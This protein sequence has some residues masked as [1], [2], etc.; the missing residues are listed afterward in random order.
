MIAEVN[1]EL[2]YIIGANAPVERREMQA[3]S[4]GTIKQTT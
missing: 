1:A 4:L 3:I 2:P